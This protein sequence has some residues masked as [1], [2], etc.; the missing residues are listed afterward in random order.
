MVCLTALA[1]VFLGIA[2]DQLSGEA[3][4][5]RVEAEMAR[6]QDYVV[7]LDVVVDVERLN[8]PPMHVQMFYKHPDKFHFESTGFA[9]LPREGLSFNVARVLSQF[10]IVEVAQS[11]SHVSLTLRPQKQTARAGRLELTIDTVLWKPV[12]LK[13]YLVDG[14]TMTAR[15]QYDQFDGY[16]M[17]SHLRVEF[18]ASEEETT[19]QPITMPGALPRAQVPRSGTIDIRYSGYKINTGLSDDIFLPKEE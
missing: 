17:P 1:L 7:T 19:D 5:K 10:S 16:I 4:L 18:V 3:M 9:L 8:V 6:V 13:S 11:N 12:V 2:P 15:F 14:R